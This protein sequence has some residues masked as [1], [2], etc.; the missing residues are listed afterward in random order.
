MTVSL[1]ASTETH[2]DAA[3]AAELDGGWH[4]MIFSV[5]MI[6]LLYSCLALAAV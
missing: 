2:V 5:D 1:A 4:K 3:V 6:L